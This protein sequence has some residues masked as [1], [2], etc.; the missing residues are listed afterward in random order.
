ENEEDPNKI[1]QNPIPLR[2]TEQQEEETNSNQLHSESPSPP[3]TPLPEP[4]PNPMISSLINWPSLAQYPSIQSAPIINLNQQIQGLIPSPGSFLALLNDVN[5]T[6]FDDRKRRADQ[7]KGVWAALDQQIDE[8]LIKIAE[9]RNEKMIFWYGNLDKISKSNNIPLI[10]GALTDKGLLKFVIVALLSIN[11]EISAFQKEIANKKPIDKID[12]WCMLESAMSAFRDKTKVNL[13]KGSI[14]LTLQNSF[15]RPPQ[16]QDSEEK[17][18][19][20]EQVFYIFVE[21][22]TIPS[23]DSETF[24]HLFPLFCVFFFGGSLADQQMTIV[25]IIV[26]V[27]GFTLFPKHIFDILAM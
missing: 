8:D 17:N 21:P 15:V 4:S 26:V 1:L 9:T 19:E 2:N 16:Q 11:Q 10:A 23:L 13:S 7:I 20:I 22:L 12:N 6:S 18:K 5:K 14:H 3:F 25:D 24:Q 27:T